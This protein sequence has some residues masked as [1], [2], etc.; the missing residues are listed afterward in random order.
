MVRQSVNR[1]TVCAADSYIM[2]IVH[3]GCW[4]SDKLSS[5]ECSSAASYDASVQHLLW[6]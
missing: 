6:S 2:Y 4:L 3:P 5:I 1:L